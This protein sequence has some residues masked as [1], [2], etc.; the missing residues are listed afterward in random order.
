MQLLFNDNRR[1]AIFG[2]LSPRQGHALFGNSRLSSLVLFSLVAEYLKARVTIGMV[3]TKTSVRN[4]Q[5]EPEIVTRILLF[6]LI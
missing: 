6:L 2:Q 1:S 5:K 3:S 4:T